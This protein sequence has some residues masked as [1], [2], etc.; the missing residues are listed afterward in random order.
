MDPSSDLFFSDLLQRFRRRKRLTQQQLAKLVGAS[1]S[2][3]SLWERGNYKPETDTI[4]YELVR[5]LNLSIQEQ[6]QFFEAYAVTAL[7][8]SFHNPPAEQNPYFTGREDLLRTLHQHLSAGKQVALTQAISGLGGIGKTQA[9]LEYAYRY[10]RS[11]HDIL[12][13]LADSLETLMTSYAQLATLLQLPEQTDQDQ[14]KIIKA[15]KRWLHEHRGWLL[16]LD[17]VEDLSL[18]SQ[19][20]PVNR[21]GAVLLTTRRQV[22]EPV[23]QTIE[24][25]ILPEK[26]GATFLLKRAKLLA[27][28]NS[29]DDASDADRATAQAIVRVLD[30]LPLALDQAGA[31]ILETG[32]DLNDYLDLFQQR[33]AD[34]LKRRGSVSMDHPVPVTTTFS[35][36]FEK[37]ERDNLT[38]AE[39]LRLCAFLAPDAIPEEMIM[40]GKAHLGPILQ[41][42]ASD[43]FIL[44]EAIKALRTLSLIRRNSRRKTFSIHRL[45]QAVLQQE[46][47][48]E[49][50]QQWAMK[51]V[52]VCAAVFPDPDVSIWN[53]CERYLSHALVCATLIQQQRMVLSEAPLL[54]NRAGAYFYQ[55][56]QHSEAESL[57][58]QALAIQEQLLGLK[59]PDIAASL[60]NLGWLY[61]AMGKYDQVEDLFRRALKLREQC[62][63]PEHSDTVHSLNNL[64]WLYHTQ[65]RYDEEEPLVHRVLLLRERYMGPDHIMTAGAMYGVARFY[66]YQGRYEEAEPLLR[67]VLEIR[68]QQL[69]LEHL[70]T[71]ICLYN[72]AWLNSYGYPYSP[73]QEKYVEAEQLIQRVLI[74]RE[75]HL[76]PAHPDIAQALNLLAWLYYAQRKYIEAVPLIQ[77]ALHIREQHLGSEHPDTGVTL[78]NYAT[79]LKTMQREHEL[80][81]VNAKIQKLSSFPP[82]ISSPF[83]GRTMFSAVL[84]AD[85]LG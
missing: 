64:A 17:N 22:A 68:E 18:V 73:T 76:G 67:R 44:N 40:K 79:L 66:G 7:R 29:L 4:L 23:A 82:D 63:G 32:C 30:G 72:L 15:V 80:A 77:R 9:A 84:S 11:Y 43:P 62:L 69:G 12:W 71:L 10:Q 61:H 75:Q 83:F 42:L 34:L 45:V 6:Q 14:N 16:I 25:E 60:N 55:R 35:L 21:Q 50:Y 13:V 39:L 49:T 38:A 24:L 48:R 47:G 58:L 70:E 81:E 41:P 59:H 3:V 56:A 5:V 46:M 51:T 85:S 8:S 28:H 31:Y 27:L 26:E 74:M 78:K 2:S 53:Q 36:A 19:F 52:Q 65:G 37:I 1:R 57:A 54:L 33:Q 20:V